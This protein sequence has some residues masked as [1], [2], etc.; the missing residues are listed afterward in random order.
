MVGMAGFCLLVN[1]STPPIGA[2][3]ITSNL[4]ANSTTVQET[5]RFYLYQLTFKMHISA[6]TPA[7]ATMFFPKVFNGITS[8]SDQLRDKA[9][10]PVELMREGSDMT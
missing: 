10:T 2:H 3:C 4:A 1:A 9:P 5:I 6:L 7:P 8:Y